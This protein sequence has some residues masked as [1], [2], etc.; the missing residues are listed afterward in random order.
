MALFSCV[1]HVSFA[2]IYILSQAEG[3]FVR[4]MCFLVDNLVIIIIIIIIIIIVIII[5]S[6]SLLIISKF[7]FFFQPVEDLLGDSL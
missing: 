5:L 7:A 1:P 6:L 3:D 2:K 4:Q